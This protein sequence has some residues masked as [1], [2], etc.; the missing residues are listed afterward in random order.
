MTRLTKDAML[1]CPKCGC[2]LFNIVHY[3]EGRYEATTVECI[4]CGWRAL[5]L[6]DSDLEEIA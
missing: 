1:P 5:S 4:D 3:V 6:Y 2:A